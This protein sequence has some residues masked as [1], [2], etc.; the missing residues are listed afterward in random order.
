MLRPGE[1]HALCRDWEIV[2]A[3]EG[4][5]TRGGDAAMMAGI[6]ARRPG[7]GTTQI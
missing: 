2:L 6:V 7:R 3:H 4:R 5:V 1:L